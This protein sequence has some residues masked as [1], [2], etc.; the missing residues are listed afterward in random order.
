MCS[1]IARSHQPNEIFNF[2]IA[3]AHIVDG[4]AIAA[5]S[6]AYSGSDFQNVGDLHSCQITDD[7]LKNSK[8]LENPF[9]PFGIIIIKL[10]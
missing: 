1:D 8:F 7:V 6:M 9:F 4:I 10:S 2:S 5:Y 3:R